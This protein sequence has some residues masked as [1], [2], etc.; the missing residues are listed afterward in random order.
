MDAECNWCERNH[1]SFDF[2]CCESGKWIGLHLTNPLVFY[3]VWNSEVVTIAVVLAFEVFETFLLTTAGSAPLLFE[4]NEDSETLAASLMGDALI[5]GGLGLVIGYLLRVLFLTPTL[6]SSRARAF[7]YDA[8]GTRIFYMIVYIGTLIGFGF[9]GFETTTGV[10]LGLLATT[11]WVLMFVLIVYPCV[12]SR[13]IDDRMLWTMRNGEVWPRTQ[14]YA[15]FV[16]LA[17]IIVAA[18]APHIAPNQ[19][20]YA[21]NEWY[22]QWIVMGTIAL[23]LYVLAFIMSVS[24]Q[25]AYTAWTLGGIGALVVWIT[26]WLYYGIHVNTTSEIVL[27]VSAGMLVVATVALCVAN[28]VEWTGVRMPFTRAGDHLSAVESTRRAS[29]T[30]YAVEVPSS[31][32]E[33]GRDND[34]TNQRTPLL[35]SETHQPQRLWL[36]RRKI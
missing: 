12:L 7:A 31:T 8:M 27:Y 29:Q 10:R 4:D 21:V 26:A 13:P 24:R 9:A 1:L 34:T 30:V 6:V 28:S 16:T 22:Q 14:R 23:V 18:H 36:R 2:L 35:V 32:D 25:D 3:I 5:Q 15:F 17:L 11:V 19:P 20:I 33:S